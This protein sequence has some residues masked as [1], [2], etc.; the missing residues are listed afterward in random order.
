MQF[1]L[2]SAAFMYYWPMPVG[3]GGRITIGQHRKH[4][5][6]IAQLDVKL[7][8]GLDVRD[9]CQSRAGL[10]NST[11]RREIAQGNSRLKIGQREEDPPRRLRGRQ[12]YQWCRKATGPYEEAPC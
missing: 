4:E 6:Q 3:D 8:R 2:N 11:K 7:V 12:D 10:L 5:K 1:Q 9:H